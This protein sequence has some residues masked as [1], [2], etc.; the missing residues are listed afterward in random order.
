MPSSS[1]DDQPGAH[2]PAATEVLCCGRE[3]EAMRMT[4][5]GGMAF[6]DAA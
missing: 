6:L 2:S 1:A 3:E 4:A 5:V